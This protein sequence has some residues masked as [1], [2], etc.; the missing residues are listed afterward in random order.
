MILVTNFNILR[1]KFELLIFQDF[2]EIL[3]KICPDS[4][5]IGLSKLF[6]LSELIDLLKLIDLFM[7]ES[8]SFQ[9][10]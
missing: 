1:T 9:N 4:R 2:Q 7:E 6:D 3:L 10:F 5:S 8:K